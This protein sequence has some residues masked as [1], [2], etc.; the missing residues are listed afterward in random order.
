VK[1]RTRENETN[2]KK[3]GGKYREEKKN[4]QLNEDDEWTTHN[5]K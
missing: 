1:K 4:G 5:R 2:K 3:E